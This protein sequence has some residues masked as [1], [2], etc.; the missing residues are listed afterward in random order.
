[1][2]RKWQRSKRWDDEHIPRWA[3][4]AKAVVRAFSSISLAVVLLSSVVVYAIL[5][6]VP[7][8]LLVLGVTYAFYGVSLVITAFLAGVPLTVL[9][10][11]AS[12]SLSWS[13]RFIVSSLVFVGLTAAGVWIWSTAFW[14]ALQYDPTTRE[15]VRFF[16]DFVAKY[17]AT[18]LRRLPG[19]EMTEIEFYS[20]WPLRVILFAF[21]ANMVVATV[22]RIEFVFPNVGVL[23]V[24][25]GIVI[26]ALGS[27]YYSG[28]KQEGLAIL[29]AGD[30]DRAGG[31]P[32]VGPPTAHFYDHIDVALYLDQGAGWEQRVL[33]GVP[34]YNDY[35]LDVLHGRTVMG[36]LGLS[37]AMPPSYGAL[38]IEAPGQGSERIDPSLR[39]RVVGYASFAEPMEDWVESPAPI[40]GASPLRVVHLVAPGETGS[41]DPAFSFALHPSETALR[42]TSNGQFDVEYRIDTPEERW[43]DVS[44][45]VPPGTRATIVVEVPEASFRGA[46]AM[47]PGEPIAIGD[48]GYTITPEQTF[49]T[50]PFAIITPGY[51]DATS[52]VALLR[53]DKPDGTSV[54]RWAYHRF[55]EISQDF[56][57]PTEP[58]ARPQRGPADPAIR[59]AYLDDSHAQIYIDE[60]SSG[61]IR[62]VI[63]DPRHGVRV[64]DDVSASGRIPDLFKSTEVAGAPRVD[65]TFGPRWAHARRIMTPR[66]VPE[67]ER[68]PQLVGTHDMAMVAVEVSQDDWSETVWVGASGF[69]LASFGPEPEAVVSPARSR[70][71]RLKFG[72]RQ[73][74]LPGFAIQLEDFQMISYDHRGAPRDYQSTVRVTP[75]DDAPFD[76]YTHLAKLN[77][78]LQAPF[79]WSED[80]SLVGNVIGTLASRL[81]PNQFKLSQARWDAG[82]WEQTQQ[83]ADQGQ[84]S[85]PFARWTILGV[86]N[87]PGIHIIALGGILMALGTPW[88]FYVKPLIMQARKRKLQAQVA[89]APPVAEPVGAST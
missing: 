37:P 63:R 32:G 28:L 34:R 1:M 31:K 8:G 36:L 30:L 41:N 57:Q 72:S 29:R 40:S 45:T 83:M 23:T 43:A 48:T 58:G 19:I 26:M 12:R 10:W 15:G 11:R 86:G 38:D 54:E 75:V 71:V 33:R 7:I 87:N 52:A 62:A 79:M 59:V 14:P 55:P 17:D 89:E 13:T 84:I 80:R 18:T 27:V 81:N 35:N 16:A 50:P 25:T 49:P 68:D 67:E 76:A 82:G 5:A 24:H 61:V 77:A 4:P 66:V 22:R 6:S 46:F 69:P 47:T 21:V 20:A 64:F 39:F 70:P 9:A 53:I 3:W 51:E 44:E 88:A 42:A 56:T 85:A 65:L 73:R 78:P 60:R 74:P 2:S